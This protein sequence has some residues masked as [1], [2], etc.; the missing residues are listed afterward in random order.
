MFGDQAGDS[1]NYWTIRGLR[2]PVPPHSFL[3][4]WV[5]KMVNKNLDISSDKKEMDKLFKKILKWTE[6]KNIHNQLMRA[7][8][9]FDFTELVAKCALF[10]GF[11]LKNEYESYFIYL[12]LKKI[13]DTML[14]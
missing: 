8:D 13:K 9:D 4:L 14:K 5:K 6:R 2:G 3:F 10:L 12:S 1:E 11:E 7:N